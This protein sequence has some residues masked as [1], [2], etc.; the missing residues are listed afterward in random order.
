MTLTTL[1]FIQVTLAIIII[2]DLFA[3]EVGKNRGVGAK[4]T[5][6]TNLYNITRTDKHPVLAPVLLIAVGAL[7]W[8][9]FIC[10]IG[11]G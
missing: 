11:C 10:P 3:Y 5:I 8:H 4:Y 7:L 9:L 2:Y 6:S 1:L